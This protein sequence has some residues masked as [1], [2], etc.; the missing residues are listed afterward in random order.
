MASTAIPIPRII[1]AIPGSVNV[2]SY[3]LTMKRT[4]VVYIIS[5]SV[6]T[7]PGTLYI[8]IINIHKSTK[9]IPAAIRLEWIASCPNC[10]PTI[11]ELTSLSVSGIEPILIYVARLSAASYVSIPVIEALPPVIAVLTVG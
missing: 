7:T 2:R 1:P 3:T 11:L 6:A 9:P 4:R 8:A 10:A 5:E